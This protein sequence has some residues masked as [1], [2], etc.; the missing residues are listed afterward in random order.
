MSLAREDILATSIPSETVD[1][2]EWDGKVI[3]RGLS[4]AERDQYE[5]G[6]VEF[7]PDGRVR[8]KRNLQ[9]VRTSLVVRCLVDEAGER[10]FGDAD[11]EALGAKSGA[12]IERLWIIARRLSGMGDEAVEAAVEDFGL[13]QGGST[14]NA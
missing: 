11:I 2:P 10:L 6:L 5:S 8:T 4:A 12:V 13:A 1:V 14:S 9:N 3:V 7:L